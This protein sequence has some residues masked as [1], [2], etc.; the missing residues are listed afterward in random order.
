MSLPHT[1]APITIVFVLLLVLNMNLAV[2]P[3]HSF[4]FFCQIFPVITMQN[5]H[6]HLGY[7]ANVVQV[8]DNVY[9]TIVNTM[10]LTFNRQFLTDYCLSPKM[11]G[12]DFCLLQYIAALYPL[13]VILSII[14]Y[15][16]GCV[17]IKYFWRTIRCCCQ[18]ENIHAANSDTWFYCFFAA[19][20][21][22]LCSTFIS[23]FRIC[24]SYL[25]IILVI[26]HQFMFCFS[27][28][29]TMQYF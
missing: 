8:I 7:E 28:V 17:P 20:L 12:M 16:P 19:N 21:C 1:D 27:K 2:G 9:S 13:S 25:K 22:S 18:E 3:V 23:N 6:D 11:N 26:I 4:I 14:S 5:S 29:A 15:C 10:W 24:S